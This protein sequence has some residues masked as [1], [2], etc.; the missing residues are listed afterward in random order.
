MARAETKRTLAA[1]LEA[2]SEIAQPQQESNG[3][4]ATSLANRTP[5]RQILK[6][7]YG[8]TDGGAA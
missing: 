5:D 3:V 4:N 8:Q 1:R 2:E 7:I 6:S